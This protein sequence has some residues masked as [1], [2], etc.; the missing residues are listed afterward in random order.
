MI[1][2]T[3]P[4]AT[5]AGIGVFV[6]GQVL[7]VGFSHQELLRLVLL[8]TPGFAA[9]VAAYLAPRWK[10]VVGMSMAIYGAVLGELM[11]R[12]YEYFGGH[13][14]QIGGLLATLVILL[15]YYLALSLMGSV[16]GYFLSRKGKGL[17]SVTDP[18]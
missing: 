12:V 6:F 3:V 5:L 9:F 17:H 14:D 7:Y 18:K 13:V 10:I 15:V 11:A 16:G 1:Q 8:G 4:K 2:W